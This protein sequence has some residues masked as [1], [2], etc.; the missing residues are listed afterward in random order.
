MTLRINPI[1]WNAIVDPT[2]LEVWNKVVQQFWIDT[3]IPLSNDLKT[4]AQMSD[5]EKEVTKKVFI[6]LT[7]LDTVQGRVGATE[8]MKDAITPHEADVLANIAFME[9]YAPGTQVLTSSGWIG[10]ED[11]TLDSKIAQYEPET[12]KITFVNPVIV[13]NHETP[14]TFE[15]SGKGGAHRQ[16]VSGG[17]RMYY[18]RRSSKR[19]KTA[20]NEYVYTES[21]DQARDLAAMGVKTRNVMWRTSGTSNGEMQSITDQDRFRISINYVGV[22]SDKIDDPDFITFEVRITKR[23]RRARFEELIKRLQYPYTKSAENIFMVGVPKSEGIL[24][25]EIDWIDFEKISTQWGLDFLTE[26]GSWHADSH[27]TLYYTSRNKKNVDAVQAV[28][29]LS[30]CASTYR[31]EEVEYLPTHSLRIHPGKALVSNESSKAGVKR[32]KGETTVYAIQ[33]PSTYLVTRLEDSTPVIAGNC[34]HAKSYSSIFSTLIS[35]EE[36]RDIYR[37]AEENPYIE[38]KMNLILDRYV[39]DDPLKKKIASTLLESFLFYSGF[40][41]PLYLSARGKL[42]NTADIIRLILADESV[43][44]FYIGYKYQRGLDALHPDD[45]D[46]YREFTYELLQDL[47]DNEVKFTRDIYSELGL[48]D[49]VITFLKYNAN[50]A[51]SNLGYDPLF[52]TTDTQVNPSILSALAPSSGE[53]HDFFSGSGSSYAVGAAED[54]SDDDWDD[55]Y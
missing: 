31:Y 9:A 12:E 34:V 25:T 20:D 1:N 13:S 46:E 29:V 53:S 23:D 22:I 38:T 24:H 3:K 43:H 41:W 28:A 15:F 49:Q 7:A 36:I 27:S 42:T 37:W 33:V 50:K 55:L 48:T 52:P 19:D 32:V 35:S 44:G 18:V 39:A 10:V 14:E 6:S 2:D 11:V 4:W 21:V 30:S 16:R 40:F 54:L 5:E 47:Y 8:L 51:L 26:L 45:R 17:H